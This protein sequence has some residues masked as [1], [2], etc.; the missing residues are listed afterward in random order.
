MALSLMAQCGITINRERLDK[1]LD[2]LQRGTGTNGYVWYDAGI[3]SNTKW[4]DMGRTGATALANFLCLYG[5]NKYQQR[6][7]L[8]SNCLGTYVKSF[9]DTHGSPVLGMAWQAAAANIRPE[10][11]RNLMNY[12]K[13]WFNLAHCTNG[14]FHYQPNRDNSG[15]PRGDPRVKMSAIVAFSLSTKN[16]NLR[17]TGANTG[18][19]GSAKDI[20][21]FFIP[22]QLAATIS[23]AN[24]SV[25]VPTTTNVSALTPSYTTS[26][27]A[28]GNPISGTTRNFTTPQ[29]YTITAMDNSTKDY[30]VT[31]TKVDP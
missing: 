12:H 20:T 2:F 31:V 10:G 1:A 18:I 25:T 17:I 23:G 24:I 29:A 8:T 26:S 27:L 13:W 22:G 9:P 19:A 5:D 14:T 4:A 15:Y 16:K 11:F 7:Q 21:T 3:V 30:T 28:T 6:A